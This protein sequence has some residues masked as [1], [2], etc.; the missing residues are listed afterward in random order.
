MMRLFSL[1][2]TLALTVFL[3]ACSTKRANTVEDSGFLGADLYKKMETNTNDDTRALRLYKSAN[4]KDPAHMKRFTKV[5]LNPIVVYLKDDKLEDIGQK[6]AQVIANQFYD[7]VS[8]ELSKDYIMVN[9]TGP[10]VLVITAAITD[11]EDSNPAMNAIS[12]VVPLA[13]V[14]STAYTYF[15]DQPSYQGQ[16]AVEA[17]IVDGGTGEILVAAQDRR[18]GGKGVGEKTLSSWYDV[19]NALT[20]WAQA[21]RRSLCELRGGTTCVAP[22]VK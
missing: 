20:F 4:A 14:T 3:A 6:N 19:E 17:K 18:L 21:T 16:V 12:T 22:T 8:A 7:K 5:L 10:D 9:T 1:F 11:L 2:L 15:S 13:A